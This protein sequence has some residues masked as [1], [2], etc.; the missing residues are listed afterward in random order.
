MY[1]S[2]S[3]WKR[4]KCYLSQTCIYMCSCYLTCFLSY[5]FIHPSKHLSSHSSIHQSILSSEQ[6]PTHPSIN[7]FK[8]SPFHPNTHL[9]IQPS[10]WV[11]I[12]IFIYPS[13]N[14]LYSNGCLGLL[15]NSVFHVSGKWQEQQ[16]F[17]NVSCLTNTNPPNIYYSLPLTR[18]GAMLINTNTVMT[19]TSSLLPSPASHAVY[20]LRAERGLLVEVAMH[21]ITVLSRGNLTPAPSHT[22]QAGVTT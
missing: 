13:I 2:K 10:F 6:E 4:K 22:Q 8:L 11:S 15:I 12:Q 9:S 14:P 3:A 16:L 19:I 18:W 7:P 5:P 17:Q 21:E 1:C 20:Y